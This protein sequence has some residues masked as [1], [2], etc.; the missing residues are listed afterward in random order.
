MYAFVYSM[1]KNKN[2]ANSVSRDPDYLLPNERLYHQ[3]I[4]IST[5]TPYPKIGTASV[6]NVIYKNN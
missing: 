1:S 4:N 2:V 5:Y 3:L 6:C